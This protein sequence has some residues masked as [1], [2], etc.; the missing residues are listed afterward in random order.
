M[1]N[2]HGGHVNIV[3]FHLT[4]IIELINGNYDYKQSCNLC[5][6]N[7]GHNSTITNMGDSL[8]LMFLPTNFMW[9]ESA[10]KILPIMKIILMI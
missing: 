10:Y 5:I 4:A 2:K 7:T 6:K 8:K 9:T 1:E 3:N